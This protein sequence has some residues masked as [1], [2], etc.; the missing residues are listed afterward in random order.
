LIEIEAMK[1]DHLNSFKFKFI[2]SSE[3]MI[4]CYQF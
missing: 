2:P 4:D 3:E 1:E